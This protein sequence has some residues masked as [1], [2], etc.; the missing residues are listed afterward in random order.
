MYQPTDPSG[1]K[2]H[3]MRIGNIPKRKSDTR[4]FPRNRLSKFTSYHIELKIP[5]PCEILRSIEL[6]LLTQDSK[7][8]HTNLLAIHLP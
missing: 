7:T 2:A 8:F 6:Y 5:M 3:G 4:S 1:L